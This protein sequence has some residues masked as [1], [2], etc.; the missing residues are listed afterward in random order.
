MHVNH[1]MESSIQWIMDSSVIFRSYWRTKDWKKWHPLKTP[2]RFVN[3][4]QVTWHS[5]KKYIAS[6]IFMK[7]YKK[8]WS[9]TAKLNKIN[10]LR[11]SSGWQWFVVF[12]LFLSF[13]QFL[14][15]KKNWFQLFFESKINLTLK[16]E[17]RFDFVQ[18]KMWWYWT[19]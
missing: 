4:N 17:D 9:L 15:Y 1:T 2:K 8:T 6:R 12:V 7:I 19:K 16:L 3:D 10:I 14:Y 11:F 5:K 13:L 18:E